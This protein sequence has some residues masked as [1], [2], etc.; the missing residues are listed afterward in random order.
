MADDVSEAEKTARIVELQARQREI[1]TQLHAQAVGSVVEVLIDSASRRG[2][3]DI[4]GRT[5]G[6]VVVAMTAPGESD[7]A[8]WVG[9]IV[10]ARVEHAGPHALKG[11]ALATTG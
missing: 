3:R 7:P 5:G 6:H 10:R 2:G 8:A 1:Q 9:R 11:T 4:S